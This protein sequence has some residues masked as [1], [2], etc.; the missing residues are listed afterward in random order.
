MLNENEKISGYNNEPVDVTTFGTMNKLMTE[1]NLPEK[2]SIEAKISELSKQAYMFLKLNNTDEAILNFNKVLELDPQN[3]YALVGL[4]DAERK[5][6]NFNMAVMF[7]KQCLEFHPNN[8]YALFGLADCFKSMNKFAEAIEVWEEYLK[9]DDK[10]VTVLTRVADAYRKLQKFEN[11]EVLYLKV[12]ENAPNN[13]YALIGLGHLNYDFKRYK[14]A[15]FYWEIVMKN[16]TEIIDIR[17]LTSIGNCYRKMRLY[18][19]GIYY[20]NKAVEKDSKNFYGLFGLADCYRGLNEHEISIVYWKKI[21]ELDPDNKVILTR[22]G[23]AY[24]LTNDYDTAKNCYQKALDIDFDSYAMLGLAIICKTQKRYD[25]AIKTLSR[26]KDL[27]NKNYR[28]Y[29]EL[30]HCYAAKNDKQKAVNILAEFQKMG[31]KNP[32]ISNLY[33]ELTKY[34]WV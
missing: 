21:L 1:E 16:N 5:N 26:L 11:A 7:Y 12:L 13:A 4:G 17:I 23:D 2:D 30:A 15:L 34:D 3:N 14:Q 29:I 33:A 22:M 10:N 20:F 28:V 8:N 18:D 19:K 24:R 31:I 32:A 6:E 9:F 25:E 27:D